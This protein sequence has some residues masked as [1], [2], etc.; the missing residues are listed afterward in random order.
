MSHVFWGS[1]YVKNEFGIQNIEYRSNNKPNLT[2]MNH[3]VN[4]KNIKLK[5]TSIKTIYFKN[6]FGFGWMKWKKN[7]L[8]LIDNVPCRL[9]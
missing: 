5:K 4:P 8:I 2:Y 9:S 6:N 3:T 1:L 7:I